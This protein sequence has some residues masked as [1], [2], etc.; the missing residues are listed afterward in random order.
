MYNT[1]IDLWSCGCIFAEF[2]T[3][4]P[5]FPGKSEIDQLNKIFTVGVMVMFSFRGG[6]GIWSETFT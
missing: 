4:K 6:G 5:L 3:R 1:A 2:L